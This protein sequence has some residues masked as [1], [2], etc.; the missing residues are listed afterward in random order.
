MLIASSRWFSRSWAPHRVMLTADQRNLMSAWPSSQSRSTW[1]QRPPVDGAGGAQHVETGEQLLGV[2]ALGRGTPDRLA[3]GRVGV[4]EP[5]QRLGRI[6]EA[7]RAQQVDRPFA[8]PEREPQSVLF[9][10]SGC[11]RRYGPAESPGT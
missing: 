8:D 2:P 1:L 7:E 11:H 4:G 10:Q 5:A 3:L 6:Q 9:G